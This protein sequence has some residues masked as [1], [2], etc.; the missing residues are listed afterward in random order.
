M[1]AL[2]SLVVL[3]VSGQAIEYRTNAPRIGDVIKKKQVEFFNSGN[4]GKDVVWDFSG[5]KST[6]EKEQT[7][8]LLDKDSVL[9]SVDS[10]M[11][12]R[13]YLTEDTL[14]LMGY[15]NRLNKMVYTDP[16]ILLTYPYAYGHNM[17]NVYDG[18]GMYCQRQVVK[19]RGTLIVEADA[20]GCIIDAEGDTLKNVVRVHS[21][22]TS[23]LC[24]YAPTDTLFEDSSHIKQEIQ[25]TNQWYVRGYRYPMYETTSTAYYDNME[26]VS[27]ILSAYMYSPEE[28]SNAEDMENDQILEDIEREKAMEQDIIHYNVSNTGT[29]IVLGYSLDADANVSTLVCNSRGMVYGRKNAHQAAGTDYQMAFDTTSLPKGDYVIYINVNGKVYNEKINVN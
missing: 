13:Y 28:Q 19:H 16:I 25:E 12:C 7:E 8:F 11:I 3:T 23:S 17:T 9:C 27:C 6:G 10:K 22:R 14:Q 21:I 5:L 18:T 20:E 29:S 24:M 15:E 1:M 4:E 2:Y 26:P